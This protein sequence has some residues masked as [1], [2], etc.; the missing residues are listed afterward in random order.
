MDLSA[1]GKWIFLTGVGVA[2]VGL[3]VW[4]MGQSGVPFGK[5]PGDVRVE[6]EGVSFYFPLV[7]CIVLS[8][9]LTVLLNIL[10]RLFRK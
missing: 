6:R 8:I 1:I 7:T 10:I 4:L 2:A 5:L 3:L 9:V